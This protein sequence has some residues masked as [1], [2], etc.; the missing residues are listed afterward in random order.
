MKLRLIVAGCGVLASSA[1]AE[2]GTEGNLQVAAYSPQVADEVVVT[3]TRSPVALKDT[4]AST[5]VITRDEI[6]ESQ[7]RDLYQ[8]LRSVPGLQLRRNGGR[9]SATSVSMR[10]AGDSGTLVMVDGINIESA[11]LGE[12]P[13]ENLSLDQIER[14]E[15]V[16]GP[17]SSLYGSKAMGGVIQI[18]TRRSQGDGVTYTAGVGTDNTVDATVTAS[19][20]SD[21][22]RFNVT[23]SHVVSD[24]YDIMNMD[25]EKSGPARFDDDGYDRSNLSI[26]IDQDLSE[27]V[28]W[29]LLFTRNE[30]SV[31]NDSK[32]SAQNYPYSDAETSLYSTGLSYD[33]D[34]YSTSLRYGKYLDE[35]YYHWSGT[36]SVFSH[37]ATERQQG[38]WENT[39]EF[40]PD[41][42]L[43][44]G[45]DYLHEEV[46]SNGGYTQNRR[47]NFGGYLNTQLTFGQTLVSLGLRHDDNEQF[48]SKLTGDA[49]IG[50]E[51]ME[52]VTLSLSAGTA[53][54]APSFNDLYYPYDG[55]YVGNPSLVPEESKS[56]EIGL[57]VYQEWGMASVHVYKSELDNKIDWPLSGGMPIQ[58]DSAE[59]DGVE[60]QLGTEVSEVLLA[61]SLNYQKAINAETGQDL[62][63]EPR[64]FMSLDVDHSVAGFDLGLTLYAQ[65][66]HYEDTGE[67]QFS[68]PGYGELALRVAREINDQFKV[69]AR[70]DNVLDNQHEEVSGY[71]NEG[72][73]LMVFFDYTPQ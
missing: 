37:Y 71:N 7:A 60:V 25:D 62:E 41:V 72:R 14:I 18:F 54:K 50:Y 32:Y 43:N 22:S 69:R 34:G 36:S 16:R 61:L 70:V 57:D 28:I 51:L 68:M 1:Y 26:N 8:I 53:Y 49:A 73:F 2:Q 56:A 66:R 59:V 9:G 55:Y 5:T 38:T 15:V 39:Y 47:D 10:G 24:G 33:R 3:A 45:A 29:N 4:L 67:D 30:S 17:K 19:G 31:D 65:G 13:L 21:T 52:D 40:N 44:F 42:V 12:T 63:R 48:G 23:A 46:E 11:T 64:R 58:V 20:S 35:S 6:E 27:S